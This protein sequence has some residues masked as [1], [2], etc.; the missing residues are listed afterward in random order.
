MEEEEE[1]KEETWVRDKKKGLHG[2]VGYLL[3]VTH[4]NRQRRSA[5]DSPL[6][7]QPHKHAT[8]VHAH[9]TH[10][11]THI[12]SQFTESKCRFSQMPRLKS[13]IRMHVMISTRT[14]TTCRAGRVVAVE[15]GWG[16]G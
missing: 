11:N 4:G 3:R 6:L 14:H 1:D 16:S 2:D 9:V 13:P 15:E 10:C 12:Q 7:Y 8:H 5:D